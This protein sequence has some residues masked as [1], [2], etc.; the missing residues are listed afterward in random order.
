MHTQINLSMGRRILD[1][2]NFLSRLVRIHLVVGV[3][4]G[5]CVAEDARTTLV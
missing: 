3:V 4:S 2:I 5:G 1:R